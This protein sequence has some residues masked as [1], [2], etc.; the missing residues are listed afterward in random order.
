MSN[1]IDLL[2]QPKFKVKNGK[3]RMLV[4]AANQ[5]QANEIGAVW[6]SVQR[7]DLPRRKS[8]VSNYL[9]Q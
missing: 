3:Y 5:E 6:A 2:G 9:N 4:T 1:F 8:H 7:N